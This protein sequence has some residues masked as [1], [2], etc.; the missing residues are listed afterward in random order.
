MA[1]GSEPKTGQPAKD[2][3]QFL[4][5]GLG[6][7]RY[8]VPSAQ[9]LAVRFMGDVAPVPCTPAMVV[10]VVNHRGRIFSVIDLGVFFGWPAKKP[11]SLDKVILVHETEMEIGIRVDTVMGI[12]TLF[13]AD[14][15]PAPATLAAAGG[16]CLQGV[17]GDGLIVLDIRKVLLDERIRVRE[18]VQ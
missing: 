6:D 12:R 17:T 7:E 18:E 16:N 14:I 15:Q 10:G 13:P 2:G 3:V 4:E 8:A 1:L 11:G 5:F 9:V